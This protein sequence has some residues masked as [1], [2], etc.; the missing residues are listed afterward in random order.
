MRRYLSL[1]CLVLEVVV[2]EGMAADRV[3]GLAESLR[4][5]KAGAVFRLPAR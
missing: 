2:P 4:R 1:A 3:E 5:L